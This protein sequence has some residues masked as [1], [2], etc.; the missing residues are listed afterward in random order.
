[1]KPSA[2]LSNRNTTI[3]NSNWVKAFIIFIHFILT[4][5]EMQQAPFNWISR[6]PTSSKIDTASP[7]YLVIHLWPVPRSKWTVT[8]SLLTLHSC[9]IG[10]Y[11]ICNMKATKAVKYEAYKRVTWSIYERS[12]I[13][14]RNT[15]EHT[16][17]IMSIPSAVPLAVLHR[18]STQVKHFLI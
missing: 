5:G 18:P 14:L 17:A 11:L 1:M 2:P 13:T 15:T 16:A 3:Y 10:L 6:A 9:H 4:K 8:K 12:Y 7:C